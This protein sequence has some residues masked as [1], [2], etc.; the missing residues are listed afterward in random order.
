MTVPTTAAFTGPYFPNGVNVEYPFAFKVNSTDEVVVFYLED[1]GSETIVPEADYTVVLSSN[2]NNPGGTV[3]TTAP[4]PDSAGKPLYVA[5]DPDFT[6]G[7]K[8][9]DEGAFNQSILNPTFDAG[10][11][12]SIWLRSRLLRA[13]LVPFGETAPEF[14]RAAERA[15]TFLSFGPMGEI[16]LSAGTGSDPALRGDL[17]GANG[18]TLVNTPWGTLFN[19]M[20]RGT[21]RTPLDF[22]AIGS[23]LSD[24]TAALAAWAASGEKLAMP[25][26]AYDFTSDAPINFA[27]DGTGVNG[28]GSRSRILPGQRMAGQ[29]LIEVT[30]DNVI[31]DG[32]QLV[33]DPALSSPVGAQM[34]AL[35]NRGFRNRFMN[36]Q[37]LDFEMG[38]TTSAGANP[39]GVATEGEFYDAW[40]LNNFIRVNGQGSGTPDPNDGYGEDRGDGI[41]HWGGRCWIIGNRIVARDNRDC[42]GGIFVEGLPVYAVDTT[43]VDNQAI[44]MIANNYIGIAEAG[45]QAN[46]GGRFRRGIDVEQY[47]NALVHHNVA[48]G[49]AWYAFQAAGGMTNV[50][51]SHNLAIMDCPAANANGAGWSPVRSAFNIYANGITVDNVVFRDNRA[52]FT[53]NGYTGVNVNGVG[54]VNARNVLI[55]GT[56]LVSAAGVNHGSR[57]A[58]TLYGWGAGSDITVRDSKIRGNWR[59]GIVSDSVPVLR[60]RGNYVEGASAFAYSIR[61]TP[62]YVSER[63]TAKSC[64]SGMELIT[65]TGKIDTLKLTSMTSLWLSNAGT[66]TIG[67]I[68]SEAPSGSVSNFGTLNVNRWRRN[69]GWSYLSGSVTYDP[70]NIAAGANGGSSGAVSVPGAK[71]GDRVEASF[72]L[73]TQG[74][75]PQAAVSAADNVIG[76]FSNPTGGAVDLANGTMSFK[77]ERG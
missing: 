8:F 39:A 36:M 37:V 58:I 14:P 26:G 35:L 27:I 1:D 71:A 76:S 49:I 59:V 43:G 10:A 23:G 60:T 11:L 3:T 72:S 68:N 62:D 9:E 25:K 5:M 55:E 48:R 64:D 13:F 56:Q 42:R 38:L 34:H 20:N 15:N 52:L 30:G 4:L 16:F 74:L 6:Q 70:A 44:A 69:I 29:G 50:E 7:T 2:E 75:I 32:L 57:D 51:F 12:R 63:D 22:G 46:G 21:E 40:Y 54:A 73:V 66:S 65:V 17:G 28:R 24:D 67:V 61:S 45:G 41:T 33:N 19:I 53:T 77:V 31:I 18:S 47:L